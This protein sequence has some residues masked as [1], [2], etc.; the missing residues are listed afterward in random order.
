[1]VI[2]CTNLYRG[3]VPRTC[4]G[5]VVRT[6]GTGPRY[7]IFVAEH[8]DLSSVSGIRTCPHPLSQTAIVTPRTTPV[9][10]TQVVWGVTWIEIVGGGREVREE[11][12]ESSQPLE[13]ETKRGVEERN[14]DSEWKSEKKKSEK[15]K[16]VR[17]K[18]KKKKKK[19][20]TDQ[21]HSK[22]QGQRHRTRK[23]WEP[24]AHSWGW[25]SGTRL[26]GSRRHKTAVRAVA[27]ARD[28]TDPWVGVRGCR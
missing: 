27:R 8:V 22:G 1:M 7:T 14:R 12:E 6:S 10:R 28:G 20:K 16:E 25:V 26:S 18:Q 5:G 24:R 9:L 4:T 3:P 21:Q 13:I 17:E 11:R 23:R 15:K 2:R 19:K